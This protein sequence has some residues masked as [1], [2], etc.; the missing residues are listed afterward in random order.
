[1]LSLSA[2][3]YT[4]SIMLSESPSPSPLDEMAPATSA[5]PEESPSVDVAPVESTLFPALTPTPYP[6][7]DDSV[8]S[9]A[10]PETNDEDL[11]S[12]YDAGGGGIELPE[13]EI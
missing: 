5:Q 12:S 6:S 2:V 7:T 1:M 11:P 8:S 9:Y 3:A 4:P 13:I 10:N